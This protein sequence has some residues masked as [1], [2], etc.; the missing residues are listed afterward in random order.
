MPIKK[1]TISVGEKETV[2]LS[3]YHLSEKQL[4]RSQLKFFFLIS[5]II[6]KVAHKYMKIP[7]TV[8]LNTSSN[9]LTSDG[10]A[11][12]KTFQVSMLPLC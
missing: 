8:K 7:S 12:A 2:L 11:N 9:S 1:Y 5:L 4:N 10:R 3:G 6:P